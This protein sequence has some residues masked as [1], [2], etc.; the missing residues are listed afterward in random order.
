MDSSLLFKG[1][2]FLSVDTELWAPGSM[3]TITSEALALG[4]GLQAIRS[5]TELL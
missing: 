2:K 1:T 4:K 5:D 3:Q